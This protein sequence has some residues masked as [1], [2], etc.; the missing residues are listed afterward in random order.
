M[1]FLIRHGGDRD[2]YRVRN[3]MAWTSLRASADVYTKL[4]PSNDPKGW[5]IEPLEW[6]IPELEALAASAP[7]EFHPEFAARYM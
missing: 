7:F 6:T 2:Y 1:T 5:C 3:G 4:P